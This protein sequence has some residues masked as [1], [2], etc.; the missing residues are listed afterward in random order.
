M[1]GWFENLFV[2][3]TLLVSAGFIYRRLYR[4]GKAS[5]RRESACGDCSGGCAPVKSAVGSGERALPMR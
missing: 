1:D 3:A 5:K 4:I 2:F